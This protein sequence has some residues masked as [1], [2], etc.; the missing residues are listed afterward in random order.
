M[1]EE[2]TGQLQVFGSWVS[3]QNTSPR[4]PVQKQN[5]YSVVVIVCLLILLKIVPGNNTQAASGRTSL[6][7]QTLFGVT[8]KKIQKLWT[9]LCYYGRNFACGF[10][11]SNTSSKICQAMLARSDDTLRSELQARRPLSKSRLPFY[12]SYMTSITNL[13]Y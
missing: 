11:L 5:T 3:H 6:A 10:S 9:K 7:W 12:L 2:T 8:Y 1:N 4:S 13:Y